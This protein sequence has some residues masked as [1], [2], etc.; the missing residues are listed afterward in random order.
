MATSRSIKSHSESA[1][2]HT[3]L[4]R[5]ERTVDIKSISDRGNSK[6]RQV[7]NN[8]VY[9]GG[10]SG[11]DRGREE[12]DNPYIEGQDNNS[13]YAHKISNKSHLAIKKDNPAS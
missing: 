9:L 12:K 6:V 13:Y 1:S 2:L 8:S 10:C 4:S 3:I 11:N 5:S 7:K